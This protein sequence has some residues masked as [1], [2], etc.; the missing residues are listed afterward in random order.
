[1]A[2]VDTPGRYGAITKGFHWVIA[3][4][5]LAIVPLGHLAV[6]APFDSAAA[7]ERK[8]RLFSIHKTLGVLVFA[9]ALAR[10]LW[11][12][13]QRRPGPLRPDRRAEVLLA[14][15][16]HWVLYASLVA[17]PLSGWLAHT[18]SSFAAPVWLPLDAVEAWVAKDPAVAGRFAAI[19]TMCQWVMVGA[20]ALHIA[21]A[22]KHQVIDRDATLRRMLPGGG[23]AVGA[24]RQSHGWAPPAVAAAI[25]G[26]AIL[27]GLWQ[28]PGQASSS[29]GLS[30]LEAAPSEWTV[31]EGEIAITVTELGS[32]TR[33]SFADWSAAITFQPEPQNGIHGAVEVTVALGSLTLG[34]VTDLALGR[35]FFH[36]TVFPTARFIGPIVSGPDGYFVDGT[37]EIRDQSQPVTLPFTLDLDGDAAAM[38]GTATVNRL[39]FD[40]GPTYDDPGQVGFKVDIQV[41]LTARRNP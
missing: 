6:D 1:M 33:G 5:I 21:G 17:V 36:V 19:H 39:D 8:I 41:T 28:A 7:L 18:T 14:S 16:V 34:A 27:A 37:L 25:V 29:E 40:V 31:E 13:G 10:I 23:A 35:E 3:L 20:I 24:P 30:E 2:L 12:F 9:A 4:A 15:V 22:L 32:R 38:T 26:V 11:A